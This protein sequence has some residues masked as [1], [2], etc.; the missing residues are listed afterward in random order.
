MGTDASGTNVNLPSSVT[1]STTDE[2]TK[3]MEQLHESE[4]RF[5]LLAEATGAILWDLDLESGTVQI[6]GAFSAALGFDRQMS[7]M[8]IDEYRDLIHPEDRDDM[9]R[10]VDDVLRGFSPSFQ[11]EHRIRDREGLFRIVRNKGTIVRVSPTQKTSIFG[12][13][14]DITSERQALG[15]IR[16]NEQLWRTLTNSISQIAWMADL[17]G[18]I[19]WF[20]DRWYQFSGL[21]DEESLGYAWQTVIHPDYR[22]PIK[23][24]IQ[25]CL[26]TG[27]EWD[28]TFPARGRDGEYHWF[29]SSGYPVFD[30]QGRIIHWLGTNTDVTKQIQLNEQITQ[31]EELLRVASDAVKLGVWTCDLSTF[32]VHWNNHAAEIYGFPGVT[33]LSHFE[34][35]ERIHEAD[36]ERVDQLV[37]F[38]YNRSPQGPP[39][40]MDIRIVRP[41][42][43]IRWAALT[44]MKSPE[45][46]TNLGPP[47]EIVIGTALD[48]TEHI[49]AK[50]EFEKAKEAAEAANAAK[51]SFLANMSHEIRTPIGAIMGFTSLLQ[52]KE[53]TADERRRYLDTIFRTGKALTRLIDDI[54]DLSKIEAGYLTIETRSFSLPDLVEECIFLFQEKAAEKNLR[55]G[56]KSVTKKSN[57]ENICSDPARIRQILIN[58]IGNAVKFTEKGSIEVRYRVE[59]KNEDA[60]RVRIDVEDTGIGLTPLQKEKLFQPFSQADDSTTRSYGGTGLGL[61]LSQRLAWALGGDI[62]VNDRNCTN[63]CVFSLIFSAMPCNALPEPLEKAD[64]DQSQKQDLSGRKLLVAEDSPEIQFLLETFLSSA[65]AQVTVVANGKDAVREAEDKD[66]DAIILDIQMPGLDGYQAARAIREQGYEKPL[67]ALT[68]HAMAGEKVKSREAGF[69]FHLTKPIDPPELIAVIYDSMSRS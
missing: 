51:S 52:Q 33:R 18:Q 54:L 34:I 62:V 45:P 20:N 58:L 61:A 40:R 1:R 64:L 5:K 65:G 14:E 4:L 9:E 59:K 63:G 31:R 6:N 43:E 3:R 42:G 15:K 44:V 39:L 27:C 68:A 69:N 2:L 8:H 29:L 49:Q 7:T 50:L 56:M 35:V 46:S 25:H 37:R 22:E 66:F 13:M 28:E 19:T 11:F 48:I 57:P 60:V 36:R 55:I 32:E 26:E 23:A 67:I 12:V 41:D 21:N 47:H 38:V 53:W 24:S 30:D 17:S 16:E 10:R